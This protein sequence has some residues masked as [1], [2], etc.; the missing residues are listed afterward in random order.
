MLSVQLLSSLFGK[1]ILPVCH[2]LFPC[3]N[4]CRDE[5]YDRGKRKKLRQAKHNFGG[6]NPFQEIATKK[7]QFKK[8]KMDQSSSGNQ[9]FRI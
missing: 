2:L 8:A 9:P 3:F 7:T 5:E 4:F 1:I 6:S